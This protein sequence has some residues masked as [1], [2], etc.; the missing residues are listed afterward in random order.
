M[1]CP[2]TQQ[3][4]LPAYL[5]LIPFKCWT[6]SS[7]AVNINF[8]SLLV[9]LGQEIEPS[10]TDYEVDALLLDHAPV[11]KTCTCNFY[12]PYL[13]VGVSHTLSF[14]VD[15]NINPLFV[16]ALPSTTGP[17][18]CRTI[19]LGDAWPALE[20]SSDSGVFWKVLFLRFL[21]NSTLK[22]YCTKN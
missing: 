2:R 11:T 7:E 22:I 13:D 19:L 15:S 6:S 5:H 16:W 21:Q 20:N 12:S 3:V 17:L 10:S 4:N 9:W 14:S 1:L 18:L 8:K